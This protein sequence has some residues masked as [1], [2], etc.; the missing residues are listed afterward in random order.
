[1]VICVMCHVSNLRSI[2]HTFSSTFI[3][4]RT[5]VILVGLGVVAI[6]IL[7]AVFVKWWYDRATPVDEEEEIGHRVLEEDPQYL[8]HLELQMIRRMR[9]EAEEKPRRVCEN[10]Y[11]DPERM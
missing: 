8:Q 1:M 4:F 11:E 10:V 5:V 2:C 6:I 9:E 7:I 3:I